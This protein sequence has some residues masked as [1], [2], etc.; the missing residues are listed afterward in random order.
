MTI[1]HDYMIPEHFVDYHKLHSIFYYFIGI[2]VLKQLWIWLILFL[3]CESL[4]ILC[5]YKKE[6]ILTHIL[7]PFA[8]QMHGWVYLPPSFSFRVL[9]WSRFK[10]WFSFFWWA[11]RLRLNSIKPRQ[12]IYQ[13]RFCAFYFGFFQMSEWSWCKRVWS[14]KG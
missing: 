8:H 1:L 4:S 6:C 12:L 3:G 14:N 13:L 11:I 2:P 9:Y 10:T 7:Y 5:L